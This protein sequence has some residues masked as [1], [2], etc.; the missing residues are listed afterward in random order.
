MM[1]TTYLYGDFSYQMLFVSTP[2]HF[3]DVGKAGII[4]PV[5][6]LR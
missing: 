2:Q 3:Y 1:S 6:H 5:L 4:I